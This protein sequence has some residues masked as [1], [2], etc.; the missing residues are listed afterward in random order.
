MTDIM[1]ELEA[2][3]D[4]RR[5]EQ[6]LVEARKA[7]IVSLETAKEAVKDRKIALEAIEQAI[8]DLLETGGQLQTR[9][10]L[11]EEA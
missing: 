4:L 1:A 6:Q 3:R 9:L 2:H 5:K 8:A 10:D 7:A 11:G